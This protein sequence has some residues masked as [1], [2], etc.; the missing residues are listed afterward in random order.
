[1]QT[2]NTIVSF[3]QSGGPHMIPIALTFGL[4]AAIAIERFLFLNS[5]QSIN[6]DAWQKLLPLIL[7]GQYE[8]ARNMA[9]GSDTAIGRLMGYGLQRL[10][11]T[12]RR[13]ELELA[14]EE[15]LMTDLPRI[16]RLTHYLHM[17]A[18]VAMLFGLLGTVWGLIQGF[19]AIANVDPAEKANMLSASFSV[20]MNATAFGLI[21]AIPLL[22]IHAVLQ[23]R[24]GEIVES[25]EMAAVKFLNLVTRP[26]DPTGSAAR[27]DA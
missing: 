24:T 17:L 4:G 7:Q 5:V 27:Q 10:Q 1:M 18:N 6:N 3:F 9:A 12:Q 26:A 22:L 8:Q 2:Y 25:L 11:S 23:T 14:M 15:A 21:T 13:D 19:T 20:A 16:E